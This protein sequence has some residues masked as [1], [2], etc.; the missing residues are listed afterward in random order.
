MRYSKMFRVPMHSAQHKVG[1]DLELGSSFS[2]TSYI[3]RYLTAT[4][5][6]NFMGFWNKYLLTFGLVNEGLETMMR[7]FYK[8]QDIFRDET[9]DE[10][11]TNDMHTPMNDYERE[12][13]D[14]FSTMN[15][16]S[17]DFEDVT[18][19]PKAFLYMKYKDQ[20]YGFLPIKEE[21]IRSWMNENNF[22]MREIITKLRNGV[23]INYS[24]VNML[25]EMM[26]KIPTTM[27]MPLTVTV[28]VP[29]V[30]T[31]HGKLQV[32][33]TTER[34]MKTFKINV[35]M[36]PSMVATLV[37]DVECWSPIVNHGLKV[38]N[39][40]KLFTPI[41][42]KVEVDMLTTPKT[43]RIAMRPPT[44]R[45]ELMSLETRPVTYTRVW[46]KCDEPED[47]TV[48]GEE[49]NRVMTFNK[50][51]GQK[52]FG[53]EMC[54]RGQVHKTP[55][56]SLT[57]TPFFPLSGP[58]KVV[59]TVEPGFEVPE[60]IVINLSG[61]FMQKS[62]ETFRTNMHKQFESFKTW[63][64]DF[65]T[66]YTRTETPF[67]TDDTPHMR[68][69]E[70]PYMRSE[71]TPY[72]RTEEET[73]YS[74][75]QDKMFR[76]QDTEFTP[77]KPLT[78][79]IKVDIE[80]RPRHF[81]FD[82]V[83]MFDMVGRYGK[84]QWKLACSPISGRNEPFVACYDAESL[85]PTVPMIT[86][87]VTDDKVMT[88]AR[89]T[90][91][92]TCDSDNFITL[93]SKAIKSPFQR[94][95][96]SEMPEY[97]MFEEC[98][99]KSWC[100]PISQNQFLNKVS[101]LMK[102]HIEIDYNNVPV[103]M[104]NL[105]NKM[106]LMLKNHFYEQTDIN[107]ITVRNP[108]NKIRA[109]ITVDPVTKQHINVTVKTPVETTIIHDI[110]TPFMITPLNTKKSFTKSWWG[111]MVDDSMTATCHVSNRRVK[112]FDNVEYTVPLSTCHAILAQDC[113]T[114]PSF[115]VMM[116][117]LSEKTDMKE[118]KIVSRTHKIILTPISEMNE[119]IRVIVN[120][121][122]QPMMEEDIELTAQGHPVVRIYKEGSQIKVELMN[123]GVTVCFDG[124]A[125]EVEL[126]HMYRNKQCG[127]CGDFDMETRDEFRTPDF[128]STDN[129]HE[130]YMKYI[131]KGK[132][133]QYPET[134]EMC[135]DM[136]CP[137]K[138]MSKMF[139]NEE[140]DDTEFTMDRDTMRDTMWSTTDKK[141]LM[142]H[143]MVERENEVCISL[144]R[145]PECPTNCYEEKKVEKRVTYHCMYRN[146]PRIWEMQTKIRR[147][148]RITEI[149]HLT[150]TMTRT[151]VVPTKCTPFY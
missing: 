130:F 143:K 135:T 30:M 111:T 128:T 114:N 24:K 28:K 11:W 6:S 101:N 62:M 78:T 97:R 9:L 72:M 117:K 146:D 142:K 96:E 41:N 59:L 99:D 82:L 151:E 98:Q 44:T 109:M 49:M 61:K 8:E 74:R 149:E 136:N 90:W 31:V 88:T 48:M 55:S 5:H 3:P 150:P 85:Y 50:C 16:R 113:S 137:Y 139:T 37:V 80:A 56:M 33:P 118:I 133:C 10:M 110:P 103:E 73:P 4:L 127:L 87:E 104:K 147:G 27:G 132:D 7:R 13:R 79:T 70:T 2:N 12:L 18:K 148:E 54:L 53:V 131:T 86:R 68:S 91:G 67:M 75:T 144:E 40:I 14:I 69:E 47:R 122:E 23:M 32:I 119:Q 21:M 94:L 46:P 105:T 102:Y 84:L 22:N 121:R 77:K 140:V 89:L 81:T 141:P 115:V 65:E 124:Y 66:P 20:D 1:L 120:D 57:G 51:V 39:K 45:R 29:T 26:Y 107:E 42:A 92:R 60:E 25:H 95:Y 126:S 129:I 52:M 64:N 76:D 58:N 36:K 19:E 116:R 138:R 93:K 106:F 108:E 123:N 125:T 34:S 134:S 145:I 100:S 38:L 71:E 15:M 112:T 43:V 35:D 83:H 63:E 17:R